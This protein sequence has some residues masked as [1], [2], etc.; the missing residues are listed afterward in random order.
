MGFLRPSK[1]WSLRHHISSLVPGPWQVSLFY[2]GEGGNV[3]PDDIVPRVSFKSLPWGMAAP[4]SPQRD[5][6]LANLVPNPNFPASSLHKHGRSMG[7]GNAWTRE[8]KGTSETPA[9]DGFTQ[10]IGK[11]DPERRSNLSK[12]TSKQTWLRS[13][14]QLGRIFCPTKQDLLQP[15]QPAV[16]DGRRKTSGNTPMM[17][18]RVNKELDHPSPGVSSMDH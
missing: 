3:S 9:D 8:Q 13:R 2:P 6:C 10:P 17:P 14:C 5:S 16:R 15:Q 7:S 12:V 11:W 1:D 18:V 4:R